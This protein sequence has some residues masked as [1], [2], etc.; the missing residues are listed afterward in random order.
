MPDILTLQK[1]GVVVL[2]NIFDTEQL[3]N[4][5]CITTQCFQDIETLI[6]KKGIKQVKEHLPAQYNFLP[7]VTSLNICALNDYDDLAT[8]EALNLLKNQA[9][10][11]I[12]T[13][14]L[15]ENF[16]IDLTQAWLRKQYAPANYHEL[17]HPH[18]W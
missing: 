12:L 3:S 14:T 6:Q 15:G 9:I 4:L 18:C 17:H 7:Y 11:L 16:K 8:T 1:K 10:N 13:K 5:I 2:K